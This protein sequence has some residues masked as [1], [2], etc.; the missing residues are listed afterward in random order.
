MEVVISIA[1]TIVNYTVSPVGKWVSYSFFYKKNIESMKK[2]MEKLHNAGD[3]VQHSID[4]AIRNGEEIE[5]DV[6]K[7]LTDVE[8]IIDEARKVLE[9]KEQAK[10]RPSNGACLNL[11]LRHQLSQKAKNIVK[12]IDELLENG[13]FDRVSYRLASQK[14]ETSIYMNFITFE[15][16]I[17]T[18]KELLESLGD[19]NINLIGLW[20]MP[21]IGKTTLAREVAKQAKKEKLFDEVAMA[22]VTHS[23]D[24]RRIQGEIADMLDLKFDMET[25]PGRA[26]RLQERLRREKKILI[27]LDDI[28]EKLDLEAIGIPCEGCKILMISRNQNVLMS[29]MDTQKDIGLKVLPEEEAWS[30]FEKMVGDSIKDDSFRATA[31]EV[32]KECAGLPIALVTVSKALKKK[33][34]YEWKDALRQLRSPS[35]NFLT[36][37]QSTIYS[38]IELSYSRLE[39]QDM[40]SFF[41]L[42]AHMG[43]F[44]GYLDLLKYCYGL[45]LFQGISTLEEARNR[46][47]RLVRN[48]KDSCL[49]LDCP[50]SSEHFVMHD[51]VR[52]VAMLI[53]SKDHSIFMVR[54]DGELNKW[55]DMDALK[56][57]KTL[58][59]F[60]GE[61]QDLPNEMECP[62]L[63]LFNVNGG[64]CS[65]QILETFFERVGELKVL[66]FTKMQLPSLPSS[67]HL[68]RSLQ[69][70]CLEHC[71]LGDI[72][73]IGE[74]KNL[75]ILSLSGSNVSKVPREVGLLTDIRLLDLSSCSKLEL[76]PPNVLSS[77]L[78]LEELY[79][80]NSFIQWDPEGLDNNANLAELKNLSHL[81]TLEIHIRDAS[82]LPK[83]IWLTKLERYMIL[84]GN[85]RW[86]WFEKH[87][88]WFDNCESRFGM[89]ETSRTLK[90]KLQTNLKSDDGIRMLLKR[91]ENLYLDEL[92]GVKSVVHELDME[93]FQQLKHLHI[94]NNSEIK[95][96]VNS[97]IPIIAFPVLDTFL[98]KNMSGLEEICRGHLPSTSFGNLRVVKLESCDELKFVFSSSI[99]RG[100]S[101]L[102]EL[103]IR[104]CR[105]MGA[106]VLKEEGEI[107][108]KNMIVFP[109]LRCLALHHLPKLASFFTIKSPFII[110]AGEIIPENKL[111]FY[112][113]ILDKQVVFPN[114]ERLELSSTDLED[115]FHN[116]LQAS[117]SCR[118][119]YMRTISRFQN[120][121]SLHVQGSSH[122]KYILSYS[123]ARFMVQLKDLHVLECKVLEEIL[124][125]EDLGG[126]ERSP[127]VFFPKLK[128]LC[129]KDLPILKRFCIGRK[130]KFPSLEKLQIE[131]CPNLRTFIF[132]TSSSGMI[133][134]NAMEMQPLF[135]EEVVFPSLERLEISHMDYL[136]IIWQNQFAA[137]SF[138]KLRFLKVEF[139]EQL[140]NVFQSNMLTR[141]GSLETLIMANCGALQEVFDLQS[142]N[143]NET[144]VVIDTQ[145]KELLLSRLPRMKHVW[146]KDPEPLF[147]FRNLKQ[148]HAKGCESLKSFFPTTVARF[149]K[150]LEKLQIVDCGVEEIVAWDGREAIARF[151]FPQV[152]LLNLKVLPRL[153]WFYPRVHTSEW[154]ML[155]DMRVHRCPEVE[156][157]ASEL[158][159]F[160]EASQESQRGMISIKQP[161]FLVDEVAFP[162][163]EALAISHMD[164]LKI[165]WHNKLVADSFY[166]L[167][168][169]HVEFCKNILHV[170]HSNML[171]IFQSL[172]ILRIT[173]CGLLQDVFDLQ[174]QDSK[175]MQAVTVSCLKE[176]YLVRL[177]NLRSVW[178]KHSGN[179]C[180]FQDLKVIHAKG[181]ESLES[182]IPESIVRSLLQLED[183]RIIK[184]GVKE[185]IAGEGARVAVPRF[186]FPKVTRLNLQGLV[187]LK[188]FY[189][190]LHTSEW[191]L[192]KYMRVDRCQ[193]VHIFASEYTSFQEALQER[194]HGSYIQQPLFLVEEVAF[195]SLETLVISYM[196]K[197][198]IIWH[199]RLVADSFR[200][201][202]TLRI[203]F[204]ED[205]LHVFQFNMLRRFQSLEA[206]HIN[207]CGSLQEVFELQGKNDKERHVETVTQLK[208]LYLIRLPKLKHIWNEDPEGI[209]SFENLQTVFAVGCGNLKSLFPASVARTLVQLKKLRIDSC[210][211]EAIVER[212]SEAVSRL[213][214][215]KVTYLKLRALPNLKWFS[216]GLHTS[217]WPLLTE[218]DVSECYQVEIFSSK[219]WSFQQTVQQSQHKTSNSQQPLF[220]VEEDTFPNLEI[221]RLEHNHTIWYGQFLEEFFGNLKVLEVLCGPKELAP[222]PE[223]QFGETCTL[224]L[225]VLGLNQ[226]A[227][228]S[229]ASETRARGH[230][231]LEISDTSF[232]R[233]HVCEEDQP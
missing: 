113:P 135:N 117:S 4:A 188:W 191:P 147:R 100:L 70:L 5:G 226:E 176:M 94:Q 121:L 29:E 125:T 157:F 76:I 152:T 228:S 203:R 44:I 19:P 144:H 27:I 195:P 73:V 78:K 222:P 69:T 209:L 146:N 91:T 8:V 40:K 207:D 206:V 162:S 126:E 131:Y 17:S 102:N 13:R 56:R 141:F 159:M 2:C 165:I 230:L 150:Q 111:D 151:R 153:K 112:L 167:Q 155:K 51:V 197:L 59:I 36:R 11:K 75:V 201:L 12:V 172:K 180:S 156:I 41:L 60:G 199:N 182:F 64:K 169:L 82:N 45:S 233:L 232:D 118:V 127:M 57:C 192:L 137:D 53:A 72:S 229:H 103:H 110:D 128:L 223:T 38:S 213:V 221:L 61:I 214:F 161:L 99:A 107:E 3:R 160:Q 34:L 90:L 101:L 42:C 106:I 193:K 190:G 108:D 104:E 168:K 202:Q 97:R 181:C 184:C 18:V 130:I 62:Q 140:V 217:E 49:L 26:I 23:P 136:K 22:V 25:V 224:Q 139:C 43:Y 50:Y 77:L 47:Y 20:G 85:V 15:S 114:L 194:Q 177:P 83:D 179:L 220:V 46:I 39:S 171:K 225:Q 33:T 30:L 187:E 86:D 185:I 24:M 93:G 37:M 129:L 204:C 21:G 31:T 189:H 89:R 215:P 200:N 216:S 68:L 79:V 132:N 145:L 163:L 55:P 52:D 218:L 71:E 175:E 170:F 10:S 210:G 88:T 9:G 98:L 231:A 28:W 14:I 149:L 48:L 16:R 178:K 74:L 58:S 67:L 164:N 92:K 227:E 87:E 143:F 80:G 84:V 124:L 148:I 186:V 81:T 212:G 65:W 1:S 166:N 105:I 219:F 116:Q 123:I 142:L 138:C 211:V 119:T 96:I 173:D 7:W 35:P 183:L 32:A 205:L 120:L 196:D 158:S 134:N 6:I 95:Y 115:I 154:P 54:D 66:C 122:I 198:M 174:G 208:E 109:Q 63:R 133:A